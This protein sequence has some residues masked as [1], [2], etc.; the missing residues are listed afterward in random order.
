MLKQ[1]MVLCLVRLSEGHLV[2]LLPLVSG[3]RLLRI[4]RMA[5]AVVQ[6]GLKEDTLSTQCTA[7]GVRVALPRMVEKGICSVLGAGEGTHLLRCHMA[8][9]VHGAFVSPVFSGVRVVRAGIVCCCI[10]RCQSNKLPGQWVTY[11]GSRQT[12]PQSTK[13]KRRLR[14]RLCFG[15]R[16]L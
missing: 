11:S 2:L 3:V 7:D 10:S 8:K 15:H 6:T 1:L 5:A 16:R 4:L 12:H 9:I 14:D 13:E